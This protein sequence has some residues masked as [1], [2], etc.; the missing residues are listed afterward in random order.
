MPGEPALAVG[1][2]LR[3][4]DHPATERRPGGLPKVV[5][6]APAGRWP[7][8]DLRE[9]WAY[10][11]LFRFLVWRD[12]KVRYAQTVLGAA[13]A[14]LQPVMTMVVFSLVFGKLA[15]LPTDGV[16]YPIFS[17]TA[18][19]PWTYFSTAL[20][21]ASGSLVTNQNLIT[22]IYLPRLVIPWASVLGALMD[23][24]IGF[25][26]LVAVLL[27][28]GRVPSPTALVAVPLLVGTAVLTA[29]GLGCWLAALN[30]QYRDVKYVVPFL[31]KFLMYASPI[32]YPL[33]LVPEAYR[34]LVALNPMTG[35]IAGFR[36]TLLHSGPFPW[37]TVA[38]SATAAV[39]LC[40]G[41]AFYF[42]SVE[43]KFADVA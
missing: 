13:W 42:R 3:G 9:L 17:L 22:K 5:R 16:P 10:R 1:D 18:L 38:I 28:Y 27:L 26:V 20:T 36:A 32:V 37:T 7:T 41:G 25:V 39:G 14:V 8:I 11:G 29:A 43:R 15:R 23:F 6:L 2:L 4:G 21:T 30:I 40:V 24:M 33:S 35:V 31:D 19:V 34:P 12:I